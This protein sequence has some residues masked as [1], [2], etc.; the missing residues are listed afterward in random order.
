MVTIGALW[1]LT[2]TSSHRSPV[3]LCQ[4]SQELDWLPTT[5]SYLKQHR[6]AL[7]DDVKRATDKFF[8]RE[9]GLGL[10][11]GFVT[12]KCWLEGDAV[13]LTQR[14]GCC[15]WVFGSK[16]GHMRISYPGDDLTSGQRAELRWTNDWFCS[17]DKYFR[18]IHSIREKCARFFENERKS[19]ASYSNS[20]I[21]I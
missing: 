20:W 9:R 10:D 8:T 1:H 2:L 17:F 19:L 21:A 6:P 11:K 4:L 13:T 16:L 5:K 3:S 14:P 15:C 18:N 12:N 7:T